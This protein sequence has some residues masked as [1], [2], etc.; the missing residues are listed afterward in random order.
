MEIICNEELIY[1]FLGHLT[2][3]FQLQKLYGVKWD[4]KVF[5]NVGKIYPCALTEHHAMK[6]Y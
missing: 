2:S 4:A 5:M 1:W 6:K 3:S